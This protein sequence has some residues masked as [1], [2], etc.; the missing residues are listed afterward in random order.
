M[1]NARYQRGQSAHINGFK[2]AIST[3]VLFI[4]DIN[5]YR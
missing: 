1:G 5:V 3:H 4:P 2:L